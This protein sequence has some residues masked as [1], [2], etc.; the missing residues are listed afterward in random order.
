MYINRLN[1]PFTLLHVSQFGKTLFHVRILEN[2]QISIHS[3][4]PNSGAK[5]DD[6]EDVVCS[7]PD[8]LIPH[9]TWI[10]FA[11]QCRKTKSS[12]PGEARL[13]ING[14][15]VGAMRIAY[16]ATSPLNP[17]SARTAST[18][19]AIKVCVGRSGLEGTDETA[20]KDEEKGGKEDDN[21]IMLGRTLLLEETIAEDLV[22]LFHHLVC[23]QSLSS[24]QCLT[25]TIIGTPIPWQH[26]R[27]D[28]QIL[29]M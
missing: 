22:L 8:A 9:E 12:E 19:D 27:S 3:P 11:L 24:L 7:A 29:D 25:Y 15:R 17:V 26:A 4:V 14:V 23:G 16:P 20:A 5:S 13:F 1:R 21:E 28:R 18:P 6:P 10:H 2:S